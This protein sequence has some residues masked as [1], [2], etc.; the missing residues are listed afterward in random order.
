MGG[1]LNLWVDHLIC[2]YHTILQDAE[3]DKDNIM[4]Y[5]RC[6][7]GQGNLFNLRSRRLLGSLRYYDGDGGQNVAWKW[8]RV[9]WNFSAII[10]T[11]SLCPMNFQGVD[12]LRYSS[13]K[14]RKRNSSSHVHVVDKTWN[15]AIHV[16]VV[17]WR[18]KN[19]QK[20]V[21]NVQSCCFASLTYCFFDVL[22][23]V[24][25]VPSPYYLSCRTFRV[26]NK[27]SNKINDIS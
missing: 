7:W 23:V 24:A 10:P 16:V 13:F 1:P 9:L 12:F 21:K 11:H 15:W 25:V 20:G 19:V 5:R 3:G 22:A 27:D 2:F 8:I 26:T 4:G 17:Q 14:E 6:F 18:Q